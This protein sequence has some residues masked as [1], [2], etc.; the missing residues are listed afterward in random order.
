MPEPESQVV[1]HRQRP[2]PGRVARA[3]VAV[4]VV[5][6]E[7]GVRQHAAGATS[8]WSWATVLS[9][10]LRVGCSNAPTM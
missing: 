9:S 6:G 7:P 2:E 3:E 1:G 10:A 8:A 5:L 4:D